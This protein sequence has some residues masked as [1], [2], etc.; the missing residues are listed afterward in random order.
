MSEEIY[1]PI[2]G[3][4]YVYIYWNPLKVSPEFP[5]GT[6]FYV[7]K[8]KGR[9]AFK[10]LQPHQHATNPHKYRT[11][12]KLLTAGVHPIITVAWNGE[13]ELYAYRVEKLIIGMWGF[14]HAGGLLTNLKSGGDGGRPSP[15]MIEKMRLANIGRKHT[16]QTRKRM[17]DAHKGKQTGKD[18]PMYGRS[19][20][21]NPM[22]GKQRP[23]YIGKAVAESNRRRTGWKQ[24]YAVKAKISEAKKRY[25]A[26]RKTHSVPLI[27]PKVE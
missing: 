9:R 7:G 20:D 15:E 2:P 8:G 18:N 21:K 3:E 23:E 11:I 14:S 16:Q 26:E 5:N 27:V 24:S 13:S 12:N 10:H 1:T 25:W 19:G 6:P 17:S 22:F 4:F